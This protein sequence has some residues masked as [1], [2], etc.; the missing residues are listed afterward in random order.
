[1]SRKDLSQDQHDQLA[2]LADLPDD[3]IDT[4]DIPEA[5]VE[6]WAHA[7]RGDLY[8][9]LKQPVTIRLDAD[10]LAWFREHVEKDG[11]YQTEI[12]RVLRRYVTEQERRRS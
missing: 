12:N 8:R 5:P 6:N 7:R 9:P 3:Q 2:K 1:M 4:F 11:G 10:V